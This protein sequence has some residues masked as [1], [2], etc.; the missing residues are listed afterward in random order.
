M[1]DT[2]GKKQSEDNEEMLYQLSA[3]MLK[4]L[5]LNVYNANSIAG[6]YTD[7]QQLLPT[8]EI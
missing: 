5:S 7:Q 2:S 3:M 4:S 6:K 1:P 8:W